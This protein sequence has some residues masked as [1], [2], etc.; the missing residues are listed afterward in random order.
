[1][2]PLLAAAV[3]LAV[4]A[5]ALLVIVRRSVE[6][7][8][9]PPP[10]PVAHDASPP[11]SA[12][13]DAV[14]A[15][16]DAAA[17]AAPGVAAAADRA[18]RDALLAGLRESGRGDE[19]W[20]AQAGA[21]FAALGRAPAVADVTGCYIAGCGATFTFPSDAA[22]RQ[23]LVEV[24]PTDASRAWTGGRRFSK[25]EPMPDGR[26]VVGLVLYRPD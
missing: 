5:G 19:P 12:P 21:L 22:Y 13:P 26:V 8:K 2:R 18:E 4:L 11:R 6:L 15:L 9:P 20:D 17:D 1:M 7:P 10:A 14:P 16:P 23:R 25:P 3:A 24:E